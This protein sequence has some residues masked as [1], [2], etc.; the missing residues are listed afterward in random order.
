SPTKI[1]TSPVAIIT[2]ITHLLYAMKLLA[3]VTVSTFL[4]LAYP[5]IFHTAYQIAIVHKIHPEAHHNKTRSLQALVRIPPVDDFEV[6]QLAPDGGLIL[7]VRLFSP[8]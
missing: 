3:E 5:P 6:F 1:S 4:L 8:E 7:S 2:F